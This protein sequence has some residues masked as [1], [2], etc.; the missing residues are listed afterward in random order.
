[1]AERSRA[2]PARFYGD[3]ANEVDELIEARVVVRRDKRRRI[4]QAMAK[5]KFGKRNGERR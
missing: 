2:L 1:M 3:P 4:K 5:V